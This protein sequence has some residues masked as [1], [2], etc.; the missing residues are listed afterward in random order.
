[1][2]DLNGYYKKRFSPLLKLSFP[3]YCVVFSKKRISETIKNVVN[4]HP[5]QYFF[6]LK[7][8]CGID[9]HVHWRQYATY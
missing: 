4:L 8:P 9:A 2:D 1:M 3:I 7:L 6:F 5:W